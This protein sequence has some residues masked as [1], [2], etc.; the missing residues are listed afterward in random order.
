M[1]YYFKSLL[2]KCFLILRKYVDEIMLPLKIM[3][4]SGMPCFSGGNWGL[5][6]MQ[7]RIEQFK[8]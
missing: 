6:E 8:N 3:E 4:N 7:K 5:I 2:C 1:F